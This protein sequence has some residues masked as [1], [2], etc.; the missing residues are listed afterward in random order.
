MISLSYQAMPQLDEVGCTRFRYTIYHGFRS[1][2]PTC[3]WECISRKPYWPRAKLAPALSVRL[4]TGQSMQ[5]HKTDSVSGQLWICAPQQDAQD[6]A[7]CTR[8]T[9]LNRAGG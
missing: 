7:A 5:A 4:G 2:H 1:K 9:Q 6:E 3:S 8:A